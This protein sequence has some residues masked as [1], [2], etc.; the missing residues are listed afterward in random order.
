ML[1]GTF[2]GNK[3]FQKE[4]GEKKRGKNNKSFQRVDTE[5][6]ICVEIREV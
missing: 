6:K 3:S 1:Y 2:I 4:A 5:N